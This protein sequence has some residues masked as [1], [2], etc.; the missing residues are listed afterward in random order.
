MNYR[1]YLRICDAHG[2]SD[3]RRNQLALECLLHLRVDHITIEM[4]REQPVVQAHPDLLRVPP[5]R[6][7]RWAA[8]AARET[9]PPEDVVRGSAKVMARRGV[10][11]WIDRRR[12]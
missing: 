12:T 11:T 6:M 9:L 8:R 5:R 4:T 3:E 2:Y 7:K 10:V 1:Q